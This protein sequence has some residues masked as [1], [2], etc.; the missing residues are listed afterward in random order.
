L[1]LLEAFKQGDNTIFEATNQ[2]LFGN[3]VA[4]VRNGDFLIF[5]SNLEA[6]SSVDFK[7]HFGKNIEKLDDCGVALHALCLKEPTSVFSAIPLAEAISN[8][9]EV[10]VSQH[11]D[12][13]AAIVKNATAEQSATMNNNLLNY[14][15]EA[16]ARKLNSLKNE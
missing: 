13:S 5:N 12:N 14:N 11:L 16:T 3:R 10:K 8:I 15:L 2:I 6:V 7:S 4:K 9:D 1:L